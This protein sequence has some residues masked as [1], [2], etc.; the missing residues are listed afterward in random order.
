MVP[1][2]NIEACSGKTSQPKTSN[3]HLSAPER[4]TRLTPTPKLP[5]KTFDQ[6]VVVPFHNLKACTGTDL[7]STSIKAHLSTPDRW[8]RQTPTPNIP[9]QNI[10]KARL[11]I[12]LQSK[13]MFRYNVTIQTYESAPLHTREMNAPG[14][15][16]SSAPSKR[17]VRTSWYYFTKKKHVPVQI[18][19]PKVLKCTVLLQKDQR[20]WSP[21]LT[22]TA[23]TF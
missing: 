3:A 13:S 1:I 11:G 7:Q 18:Y 4:S 5:R 8:T 22:C 16:T 12:V 17:F 15:R 2:S 10:F 20:A 19:N 6:H 9:R 23:K 14:P 21:H